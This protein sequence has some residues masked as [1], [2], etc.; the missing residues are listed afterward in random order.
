MF[1]D[2][3]IRGKKRGLS[4]CISILLYFM[5]YGVFGSGGDLEPLVGWGLGAV[6]LQ[7]RGLCDLEEVGLFVHIVGAGFD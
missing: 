7:V 4:P 5:N 3:F 6:C 1:S 2:G